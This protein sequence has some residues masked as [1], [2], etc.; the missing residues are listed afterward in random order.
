MDFESFAVGDVKHRRE[1]LFMQENDDA[2][3]SDASLEDLDSSDDEPGDLSDEQ[4]GRIQITPVANPFLLRD[5]ITAR[6]GAQD[7]AAEELSFGT[8]SL[9]IPDESMGRA[10]RGTLVRAFGDELYGGLEKPTTS[11]YEALGWQHHPEVYAARFNAVTNDSRF[12]DLIEHAQSDLA[13]YAGDIPSAGLVRRRIEQLIH[14][15]SPG[16]NY[17][18]ML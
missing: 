9:V 10:R 5:S 15:Q 13:R 12:S 17:S 18:Q 11:H 1:E 6:E 3:E 4:S 8:P 16:R 7:V 14:I 2:C